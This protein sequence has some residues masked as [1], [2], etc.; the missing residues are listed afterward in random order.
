LGG[1]YNILMRPPPKRSSPLAALP[2]AWAAPLAAA[3][4]VT[5]VY[6]P[7]REFQFLN[8]DDDKNFVYNPHFR[9]LGVVNLR[10]MFAA[11]HLG[12]YH[13]L[14]WLSLGLDYAIWGLDAAGFHLTN[15]LLHAANAALFCVVAARLVGGQPWAPLVAGLLFALHPLRVESVAWVSERRDVLSGLFYLLSVLAYLRAHQQGPRRRWLMVSLA[16]FTGGLLS[17]AVVVSLPVV[18]VALDW[19]VLRRRA[20]AEKLLY[21]ALAAVAALVTLAVQPAGVAGAAGHVTALPLLRLELSLY[22]LAFYLGKSVLPLGLFPQYVFPGGVAG[23]MAGAVVVAVTAVT[24]AVARRFPAA[25]AAWACYVA[26]LLPVLSIFR[27]DPQ[28]FAADHHTYLATLPL[29]LLGGAGLAALG[30]RRGAVAAVVLVTALAALTRAQLPV[31]RDPLS[32]WTRAVT[33][34]PGSSVAHNNLGEALAGANRMAEALPHFEAAVGLR[35]NHAQAQYN[36]GR[37][38]QQL[39][40]LSEALPHFEQALAADPAF[41]QARNDLANCLARLG[42]LDA[43][44]QHYQRALQDQPELADAHYNLANL[45]HGRRQ[46]EEAIVHYR[47]SLRLKPELADAHSNWGVSLDA[48]GR[49]AEAMEHYRQALAID[50]RNAGAHNNLGLSMEAAGRLEEARSHYR[51]A[52]RFDPR[53]PDAA[54]NLARIEKR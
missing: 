10:W 22:A 3:I 5:L 6:W 34:A 13:P 35:P 32:L 44:F 49:A 41:A 46:F 31:W 39:G 42:R 28:Q 7:A 20:W 37:G 15:L 52:L 38:L 23:W 53:H 51:Q 1:L 8:W 50:P 27:V 25:L 14:T 19:A 48:L 33:G 29:A 30:Q 24:V 2:P 54:A 36:L 18:L 16:A 47:Q 26:T 40:K 21:L 4:L 45:L 17:K 9:G 12:H 43:A 11:P